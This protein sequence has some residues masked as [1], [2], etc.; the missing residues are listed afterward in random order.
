[1]YFPHLVLHSFL[2]NVAFLSFS[3][4]LEQA[5]PGAAA[6]LQQPWKPRLAPAPPEALWAPQGAVETSD[7]QG[8]GTTARGAQRATRACRN[9]KDVGRSWI[10][11]RGWGWHLAGLGHISAISASFSSLLVS[12]FFYSLVWL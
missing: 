11:Q 4:G 9:L 6:L 2:A 12:P 7:H 5:Q 1:M 10:C 3:P 8:M